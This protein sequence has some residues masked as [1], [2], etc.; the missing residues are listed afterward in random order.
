MGKMTYTLTIQERNHSWAGRS[1]IQSEHATRQDAEIALH[2][3]VQRNWGA[4]M[5]TDPPNDA[6]E[7]IQEY[8]S[9]VLEAFE[10]RESA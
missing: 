9:E 8:F 2:E 5:E 1:P 4:E 7:M 3:Y 10:I 6:D